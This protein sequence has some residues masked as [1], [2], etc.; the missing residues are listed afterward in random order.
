MS[1]RTAASSDGA[2][3]DCTPHELVL[4]PQVEGAGEHTFEMERFALAMED[5]DEVVQA[6][7]CGTDNKASDLVR[8]TTYNVTLSS[9]P[10]GC[11]GTTVA[12]SHNVRRYDILWVFGVLASLVSSAGSTVGMLI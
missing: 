3:D 10:F 6:S 2:E 7:S 9:V 5:V 12:V 1:W 8:G 11:N 4:G